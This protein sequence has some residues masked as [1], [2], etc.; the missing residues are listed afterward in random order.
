ML[1]SNKIKKSF[2]ISV[3]T[4][5]TLSSFAPAQAIEPETLIRFKGLADSA[6]VLIDSSMVHNPDGTVVYRIDNRAKRAME[7]QFEDIIKQIEKQAKKDIKNK[8]WFRVLRLLDTTYSFLKN[9][10]YDANASQVWDVRFKIH[11]DFI[12]HVYLRR[13]GIYT[14]KGSGKVFVI[15][16]AKSKDMSIAHE[17]AKFN[18]SSYIL[19]YLRINAQAV[20]IIGFGKDISNDVDDNKGIVT[21]YA[22][23]TASAR[24]M[25]FVV[26][27][28][29]G[30][31]TEKEIA[32]RLEADGRFLPLR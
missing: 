17:I 5:T 24:G 23:V 26:Q 13:P 2:V 15:S 8:E 6:V 3:A 18:A 11:S 9:L 12:S 4:L 32:Q 20:R 28:R 14:M 25:D 22:L 27:T 31:I 10:G 16:N 30:T 19:R 29:D 7:K 1:D 21:W